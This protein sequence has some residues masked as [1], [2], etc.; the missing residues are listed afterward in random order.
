MTFI[1]AEA[2]TKQLHEIELL[3]QEAPVPPDPAMLDQAQ[4]AHAAAS[5]V[6]TTAGGQAP[7]FA[8]PPDQPSVPVQEL[9]YHQYEF[10]TCQ[11]W[12]SSKARRDEDEKGNQAGVQNVI[13]HAL[14]H[15]VYIQQAAAAQAALA[16]PPMAGKGQ[17]S[18]PSEKKPTPGTQVPQAT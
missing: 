16:A 10:Q 6:A 1:P 2:R 11:Q 3:L 4:T 14:A 5:L 7:P 9:D 17:P 13:L 18:P 12:L 8:A 15:R